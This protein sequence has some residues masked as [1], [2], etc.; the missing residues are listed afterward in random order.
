MRQSAASLTSIQASQML[1]VDM[2]VVI[3]IVDFVRTID[4]CREDTEMKQ[5]NRLLAAAIVSQV[6]IC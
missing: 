1:A 5:S 4:N 6:L 2:F 3:S